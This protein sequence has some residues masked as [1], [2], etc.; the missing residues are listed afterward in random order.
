MYTFRVTA[1]E[2]YQWQLPNLNSG[3]KT[4]D[5]LVWW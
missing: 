2:K 5:V 3:K 4:P 1:G